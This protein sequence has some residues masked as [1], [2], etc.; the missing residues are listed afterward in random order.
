MLELLCSWFLV[1]CWLVLFGLL[2]SFVG[3]VWVFVRLFKFVI[4]V[5]LGCGFGVCR[6]CGFFQLTFIVLVV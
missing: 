4:T 5:L 6:A 1:A 2:I 3:F